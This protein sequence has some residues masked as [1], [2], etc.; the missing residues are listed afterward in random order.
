MKKIVTAISS[1]VCI[2]S[3][4]GAE[5]MT[6]GIRVVD[7]GTWFRG[8]Y[9][10]QTHSWL[11]GYLTGLNASWDAERKQPANPLGQI[12]NAD[13]AYLWMDNYCRANPMSDVHIGGARLLAE[14]AQVKPKP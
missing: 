1:V 14:L 13:Q 8:E 9:R 10:L 5:P 11:D 7:C 6:S 3:S 12:K 2:A 4:F